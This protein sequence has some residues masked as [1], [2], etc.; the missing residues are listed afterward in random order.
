[1]R[2]AQRIR[3]SPVT[4]DGMLRV[5]RGG[6]Y[7]FD[8]AARLGRGFRLGTGFATASG[9]YVAV[10]VRPA[11]RDEVLHLANISRGR[12]D[13]ASG[14]WV[15]EGMA[16]RCRSG[17]ITLF[18]APIDDPWG[19][20]PCCQ[21][22]LTSRATGEEHPVG[23]E[24]ISRETVE[25]SVLTHPLT[26]HDGDSVGGYKGLQRSEEG[27][28]VKVPTHHEP[29]APG[30]TP[31]RDRDVDVAPVRADW[32]EVLNLFSQEKYRDAAR[33]CGELGDDGLAELALAAKGSPAAWKSFVARA[34]I[35]RAAAPSTVEEPL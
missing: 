35:Q 22:P 14:K 7:I 8:L 9:K 11:A 29:P 4:V 19:L 16:H 27:G 3:Y 32:S 30:R 17:T 15:R 23:R 13:N 21:S 25:R 34:G 31:H 12:W 24:D 5:G 10:E 1:M 20:C 28:D 26:S 6:F 33:M 2:A 18:V